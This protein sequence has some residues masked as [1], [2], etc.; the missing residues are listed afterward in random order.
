MSQQIPVFKF[1]SL[2]NPSLAES[3]QDDVEVQYSTQLIQ[4]LATIVASS[5]TPTVKLADYNGT[6]QAYVDSAS[7][8]KNKIRCVTVS[9]RFD[10]NTNHSRFAAVV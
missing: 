9:N 6:L 10:C 2:R 7:F 5:D 1:A 3:T 4:D 8:L